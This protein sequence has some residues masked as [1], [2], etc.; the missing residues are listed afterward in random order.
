MNAAN[1]E[2]R[3][4]AINGDFLALEQAGVARYGL[5]VT[6]ALDALVG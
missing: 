4:W 2:P 3:K 6:R 5:E 1:A